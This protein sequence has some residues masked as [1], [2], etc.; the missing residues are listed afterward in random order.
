MELT[1]QLEKNIP[2]YKGRQVWDDDGR[3]L[4]EIVEYNPKTGIGV[5]KLYEINWNK[6]NE[7]LSEILNR[8]AKY[9]AG[10]VKQK[11]HEKILAFVKDRLKRNR[12]YYMF[13]DCSPSEYMNGENDTLNAI[14]KYIERL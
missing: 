3:L 4:T 11:K 2:D 13:N 7:L 1:V 9:V 6:L 8:K 14:I 10:K 5:I 12:N